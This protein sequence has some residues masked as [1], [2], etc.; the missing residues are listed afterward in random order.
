LL[1]MKTLPIEQVLGWLAEHHPKLAES[2]EVQGHWVWL[3]GVNLQSE[4]DVRES[5]K[6][7]GFSF[8]RNGD[9]L[10]PSGRTSRWAHHG[11][12]PLRFRKGGG[13]HKREESEPA[14]ELSPDQIEAMMMAELGI[15]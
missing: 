2:A 13:G 6:E 7:L 5:I 15:A 3:A 12:H 14:V 10:L 8:K 11:M 1:F 4:P 9:H